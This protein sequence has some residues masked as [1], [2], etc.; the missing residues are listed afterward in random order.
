MTKSNK[1]RCIYLEDMFLEIYFFLIRVNLSNGFPCFL[2]EH[3]CR[4]I[5]LN[6]EIFRELNALLNAT[7]TR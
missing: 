6:V 3:A 5:W 1:H 2:R 7:D 4:H